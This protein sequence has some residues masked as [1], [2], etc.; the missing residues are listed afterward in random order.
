M[1]VTVPMNKTSSQR[2]FSFYALDFQE[3]IPCLSQR[4]SYIL[5]EHV[6][7]LEVLCYFIPSYK[8]KVFILNFPLR[9]LSLIY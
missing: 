6:N 8:T 7:V 5:K 9:K 2:G 1:Q 3:I 4:L